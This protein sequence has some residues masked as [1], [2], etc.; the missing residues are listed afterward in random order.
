ML[1]NGSGIDF[2]QNP[3]LEAA[4]G[5]MKQFEKERDFLEHVI[6]EYSKFIPPVLMNS[7]M[8]I[9]DGWKA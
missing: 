1:G 8:E 7:I 9:E 6:S 5:F 2:L 4:E 3:D